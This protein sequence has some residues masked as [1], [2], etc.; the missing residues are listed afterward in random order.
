LLTC[1]FIILAN[2]Y[3]DIISLLELFLQL[4]R[5]GLLD[6]FCSCASVGS[7]FYRDEGKSFGCPGTQHED[8]H[9]NFAMRD[10]GH[11]EAAVDEL[12]GPSL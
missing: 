10:A 2:Q 5:L 7:A 12:S 11:L 9:G 4:Q 8:N 6:G 3:G 1:I